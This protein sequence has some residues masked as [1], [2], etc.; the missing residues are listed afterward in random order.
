MIKAYVGGTFDLFHNGHVRIF[1][2][3]KKQ[4]DK[5]IV[6]VNS[7]DFAASYKRKPILSEI[8]RLELVSACKYVDMAFIVESH[9]L[10][11]NYIEII[12]PK[13]IVHGSDWTGESLAEQ[14]NIN[15][16]F[17]EKNGIEFLYLKYTDGISTSEIISRIKNAT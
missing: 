13:Y 4:C 15:I 16:E 7:D 3:T 12:K 6:A 17:A 9:E 11:R 8:E 5:L 2:N 10:Q 14:L 1:K